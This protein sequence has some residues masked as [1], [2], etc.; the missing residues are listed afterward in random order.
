MC[1]H[2]PVHTHAYT[3]ILNHIRKCAHPFSKNTY[4]ITCTTMP[5]MPRRTLFLSF[6]CY[7][8][9]FYFIF[10]QGNFQLL[11]HILRIYGRG[12]DSVLLYL[13]DFQSHSSRH[14]ILP[15][16]THTHKHTSAS[17]VHEHIRCNLL[18]L[19][20]GG[21]FCTHIVVIALWWPQRSLGLGASG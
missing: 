9:S 7:S 20:L 8:H 10:L 4:S 21:A 11:D 12:A 3:S 15:T 16:R 14:P 6:K 2:T 17:T 5:T 19:F 18:L 13:A 1:T